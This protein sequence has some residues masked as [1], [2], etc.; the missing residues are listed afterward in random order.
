MVHS[1]KPPHVG[2]WGFFVGALLALGSGAMV[3]DEGAGA[4]V[5]EGVVVLE[6]DAE[7]GCDDVEFVRAELWEGLACHA[8]GAL[9][10]EGEGFTEGGLDLSAV[11]GRVVCDV[12]RC[13]V[14][15]R[16]L[17]ERRFVEISSS[18]EDE[19]ENFAPPALE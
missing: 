11:E 15:R 3:R 16:I 17:E 2:M 19:G 6:W 1:V 5:A 7:V 8:D 4:G 10:V 18:F 9:E 12:H 13:V 14:E